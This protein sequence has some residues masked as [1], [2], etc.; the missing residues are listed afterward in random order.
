MTARGN[1][2]YRIRSEDPNDLVSECNRIFQV[3]NDRLDKIEGFRGNRTEYNYVLAQSDLVITVSSKGLVLRDNGN[4]ASYWRVTI[5]STGTLTV[6]N[7]G[8]NY[9]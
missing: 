8:R 3:M 1:T 2:P 9:P 4:P 5:D 6:T 7:I